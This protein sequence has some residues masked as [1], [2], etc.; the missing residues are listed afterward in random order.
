MT[1]YAFG[2]VVVGDYMSLVT[3]R[4]HYAVASCA[5]SPTLYGHSPFTI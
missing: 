4:N 5:V 3:G 2:P 1:D